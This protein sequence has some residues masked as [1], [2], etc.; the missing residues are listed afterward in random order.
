MTTTDLYKILEKSIRIS[1]SQNI[2]AHE[3]LLLLEKDIEEILNSDREENID[4]C[5]STI[6]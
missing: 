6:E 2:N 1:K 4:I 5:A 3:I